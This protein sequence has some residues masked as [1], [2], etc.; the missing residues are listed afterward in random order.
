MQI[1]SSLK[2]NI[3]APIGKMSLSN[4]KILWYIIFFLI[5]QPVIFPARC[6]NFCVQ[7]V[8]KNLVSLQ[9]RC[10]GRALLFYEMNIVNC[11]SDHFLT[12]DNILKGQQ[13]NQEK[14]IKKTEK[15][16]KREE[17]KRKTSVEL[18]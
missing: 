16:E 2:F 10:G 17:K 18:F 14:V 3:P 12:D 4:C 8:K 9:E 15:K 7:F 5:S 13:H 1:S 11:S 6:E